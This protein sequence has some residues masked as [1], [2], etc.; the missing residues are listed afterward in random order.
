[1]AVVGMNHLLRLDLHAHEPSVRFRDEIDVRAV[2]YRSEYRGA[3]PRKPLDRGRLAE[4]A[5][6]APVDQPKA[7]VVSCGSIH[8]STLGLIAS[9]VARAMRQSRNGGQ[10]SRAYGLYDGSSP[11]SGAPAAPPLDPNRPLANARA[12]ARSMIPTSAIAPRTG[13]TTTASTTA[14]TI[15]A[16]PEMKSARATIGLPLGVLT[17]HTLAAPSAPPPRR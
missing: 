8:G 14:T 12:S 7:A 6:P 11:A 9:R 4:V 13:S 3:G 2:T 16:I 15:V 17:P 1:M 10:S 5:L